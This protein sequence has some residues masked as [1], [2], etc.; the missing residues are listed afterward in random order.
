MLELWTAGQRDLQWMPSGE[1]LQSFLPTQ[2]LGG[3]RSGLSPGQWVSS[4]SSWSRPRPLPPAGQQ[5]SWGC[6]GTLW[7]QHYLIC[8]FIVFFN[9]DQDVN[10]KKLIFHPGGCRTRQSRC[11]LATVGSSRWWR[12]GRPADYTNS[13]A[14][15]W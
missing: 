5:A 9:L 12:A 4:S 10:N 8:S 15:Q 13:V 14:V 11:G 3:T 1:I 6:W 2:G 7:C